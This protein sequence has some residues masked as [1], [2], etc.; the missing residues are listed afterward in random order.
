VTTLE[1]FSPQSDFPA[2]H[3]RNV[4]EHNGKTCRFKEENVKVTPFL[5]PDKQVW[6]LF[7][8]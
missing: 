8:D 5:I 3:D 7:D 2:V 1:R 6:Q 4:N